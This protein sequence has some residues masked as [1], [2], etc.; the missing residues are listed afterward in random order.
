MPEGAA[1]ITCSTTNPCVQQ[2][3]T[4]ANAIVGYTITNTTSNSDTFFAK[5]YDTP[6]LTGGNMLQ[7][8]WRGPLEPNASISLTL[9]YQNVTAAINNSIRVGHVIG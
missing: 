9:E 6:G 4:G 5:L 8:L 1:T 2:V 7:E 3:A